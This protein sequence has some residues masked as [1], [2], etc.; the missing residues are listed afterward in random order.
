M[1]LLF[2]QCLG[3]AHGVFH[4]GINQQQTHTISTGMLVNQFASSKDDSENAPHSCAAF[5][6][7][8]LAATVHVA[9]RT[10]MPLPSNAVISL[11]QAYASW[12]APFT[13]HFSSRAPPIS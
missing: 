7:A 6:D 11:W 10:F 8:T 4:S 13:C 3:L 1:S 2:A 5:E 12:R 9:P